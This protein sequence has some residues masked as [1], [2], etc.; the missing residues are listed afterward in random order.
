MIL[1]VVFQHVDDAFPYYQVYGDAG[2]PSP[3]IGSRGPFGPVVDYG[4]QFARD[5]VHTVT[6]Y[7][8][9]EYHVD[10]FRY[11]EVTDLYNGRPGSNT[12][13]SPS[14]STAIP[15]S[16]PAS[17]RAAAPGRASTAGSSRFPRR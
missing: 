11:N 10:G 15:C 6:S 3:M 17:R 8:L 12:P 5:Y 7:L 2:V 1:D 14:T 13:V 9:E 4:K 16:C